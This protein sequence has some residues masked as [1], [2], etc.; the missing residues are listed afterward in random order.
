MF[1]NMCSSLIMNKKIETTLAKARALRTYLE[2]IITK[3]KDDST[4]SRRIV[5]SMLGDKEAVTELFREISVKVADRPG[6]Y[7]RILKLG[8]RKGDAAEMALIELVDFNELLLGTK[9]AKTVKATRRRKPAAKKTTGAELKEKA[10]PK[11]KAKE[12]K[13]PKEEKPVKK[14]AKKAQPKAE[15]SEETK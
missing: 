4:H 8:K 11:A 5:F 6:G 13:E 2:P 3:S 1:A 12:V 15:D 7:T 9:E 10:E 14:T